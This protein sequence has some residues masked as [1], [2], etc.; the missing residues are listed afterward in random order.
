[1]INNIFIIIQLY[2]MSIEDVRDF[3]ERRPCNI[4]HS[5]KDVGTIEYFKEVSFKKYYVEPHIL[6]FADFQNWEGQNVLEIGCGIGTAAQSFAENGAIYTGIDIS[7]T[8][9]DICMDRFQVLNLSGHFEVQNCEDL[10]VAQKYDLVYSFGVL[11]HT[12]DITKAITNIYNILK[13]GAIFKL[14]LYAK[15]SWKN[16]CIEEGLDQPEAQSGCP[17]ANTY[18]HDD[19][20]MLLKDFHEI[21]IVQTHVFPYKIE[22]YRRHEYIKHEYFEYMPPN[23][24]SCFEKNLGWHLCITCKK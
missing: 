19:V 14:M 21:D 3:W 2:Q 24:F 6:D 20:Y 17:I 9:I 7:P 1:M 4:R 13:P 10:K 16:M 12:P 18:T 23:V 22:P 11:H 15:N 5:D 8:A